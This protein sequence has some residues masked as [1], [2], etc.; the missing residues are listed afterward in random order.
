M[1]RLSGVLGALFLVA[2]F[3]G[4]AVAADAP[5]DPATV[6]GADVRVERERPARPKLAS[7]RF[8][9]ENRD[10]L[11][12]RLDALRQR[13]V[14]RK[15]GAADID[16]R[17]LA[18]GAMKAEILAAGDSVAAAQEARRRSELYADVT[19]L[20]AL[21]GELDRLERL[22]AEQRERL[23]VLEADFTGRQATA[24]LV[25]LR[26][27][28]AGDAVTELAIT[29]DDGVVHRVS[30]SARDLDAL[31]RGGATE[32][33]HVFIEPR[34]QTLTL[35]LTAATG[36][37]GTP[38]WVTLEPARDRITFLEL[39]LAGVGAGADA[40]ALSARTWLHDT[41]ALATTR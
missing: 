10:F 2:G 33:L 8:L 9:H 31:R 19:D 11:R 25:V 22:L 15:E 36:V 41:T 5:A 18:Y 39:D 27:A 12:M 17:F 28:P 26:G 6:T 40:T 24:L 3:A 21:D 32:V 30:L 20:G 16:P 14:E 37:P 34:A 4:T 7:L 23:G 29:G 13:P 38:A 35:T 1:A